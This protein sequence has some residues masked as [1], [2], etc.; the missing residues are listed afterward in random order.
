VEGAPRGGKPPPGPLRIFS[1]SLP[2][3]FGAR[4]KRGGV[5]GAY[6]EG[7]IGRANVKFAS[8]RGGGPG[9]GRTPACRFGPDT[10]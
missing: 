6:P 7:M 8:G 9:F 3:W 1:L 5:S 10:C 2:T 4:K